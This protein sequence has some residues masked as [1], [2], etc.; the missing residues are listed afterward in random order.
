[1]T[2]DWDDN[3]NEPTCADRL[4]FMAAV[5]I[6]GGIAVYGTFF[7]DDTDTGDDDGTVQVLCAD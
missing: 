7:A 5:L 4:M 6:L 2:R 1:M 3:L